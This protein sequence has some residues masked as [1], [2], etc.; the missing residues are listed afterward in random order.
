MSGKLPAGI[1]GLDSYI[2]AATGSLTLTTSAADVTG[3]TV[4]LIKIGTYLITAVFDMEH[5]VAGAGVAIGELVLGGTTRG[6]QA[7]AHEGAVRVTVPQVWLVTTTALNTIAK[8]QAKKS[9]NAGTATA[10]V[11][12]T[13]I[14]AL[15]VG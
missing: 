14:V 12:H 7:L 2:A 10:N 4:T 13:K 3:V 9:I 8:L 1:L 5:S 11:T 6:G 15:L